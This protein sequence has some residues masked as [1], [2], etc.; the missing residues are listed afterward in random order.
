MAGYVVR[1]ILALVPVLIGITLMMFVLSRVVPVDPARLYAG[2]AAP[3]EVVQALRVKMGLDKPLWQQYLMYVVGLL[4]GDLG[5]SLQ[6]GRPVAAEIARYFPATVELATVAGFLGIILGL[7]TGV[8]SAVKRDSFFD[9]VTRVLALGGVC[10]PIFWLGLLLILVFYGKLGM[11]PAWGRLDLMVPPP[12]HLTGLYLVDSVLTGRFDAFVNAS[13]HLLLPGFALAYSGAG[14]ILRLARSS[15]LEVL[16][17]DYVRTARAKGLSERIVIYRHALRNA[18]LPTLTMLGIIY[19]SL[20]GGAVLTET[21]FSWPGLG[22]YAVGAMVAF[23]FPAMM[24]FAL[25]AALA[26]SGVNLLVDVLY[27][28]C[29]PRISYR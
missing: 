5:T 14:Q 10:T 25:V 9:H 21:I 12:P 19:G 1:R 15:M 29:D 28:V 22:R 8:I 24:G 17:E 27:S 3:E 6:T 20:L 26:Y 13:W 23:D 18:L 16:G 11:F 2:D 7:P 4:R